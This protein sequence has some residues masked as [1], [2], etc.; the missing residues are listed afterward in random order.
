[1]KRK[2]LMSN[3]ELK[4]RSFLIALFLLLQISVVTKSQ[5]VDFNIFPDYASVSVLIRDLDSGENLY[6]LNSQ[7]TLISA[8]LMK[9]VTTATALENLGPQFRFSTHFATDGTIENG[10]LKGNLIIEGGGDPT[11]GSEYFKKQ[12]PSIVLDKVKELLLQQ[13][14]HKIDGGVLI[15][16]TWLRDSRFPSQRLWEDMGN[17]YGA[18][19]SALSWRD[20]SF[21]V[22]LRSPYKTG[23]ICNVVDII[24]NTTNVSFKCSVRSVA[25]NK[26]S[27]YIYGI[28]GL[29]EWEIRGTVP[30]GRDSFS[31]K[32]ALPEPGLTFAH[33]ILH[34]FNG[35]EN[36]YIGKTY[37]QTRKNS[38]P[39]IGVIKSPPLAEI[40]KETNH[41]SINLAADHLLI[42]LGKLSADTLH[43]AWDLGLSGLMSF[44][45][46]KIGPHY[47]TFKD[48]SG[49]AP[50]NTLSSGFLVD[51]LQYM[52]QKGTYFSAYKNSLAISGIS[53][54]LKSLWKEDDLRGNIYGKSGSMH[55]VVGYAGYV[56]Q[57]GK[58]PLTFAVIVNHHGMSTS[59]ARKTIEKWF[60]DF[61]KGKK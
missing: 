60:S 12:T 25:N 9:L 17:Y 39:E 3:M 19:P 7:K 13:G 41:H 1:M 16:E 58:H 53:G 32:G 31:I 46:E 18:P 51:L 37:N 15:D 52:Y 42:T 29:K 4:N 55:D 23:K 35:S 10:I 48:G 30:A 57:K 49:L 2:K 56:F 26:D 11:L 20:N 47:I 61:L 33:E 24:P 43:S 5:P 6:A 54:T 27:A 44:W 59:E 50:L 28:P 14:I 36:C 8:S 38:A 34:L 21:E 45:T 22:I 40:I